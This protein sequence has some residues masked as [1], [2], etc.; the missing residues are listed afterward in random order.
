M[1]TDNTATAAIK[2]THFNSFLDLLY[3]CMGD[4]PHSDRVNDNSCCNTSTIMIPSLRLHSRTPLKNRRDPLT[5][6]DAHGGQPEARLPG[7]HGMNEC[8]GDAGA[9]GAER[10]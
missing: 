10:M 8:G 4:Y 1:P 7:S 2:R 3:A 6:A 9:A 5:R